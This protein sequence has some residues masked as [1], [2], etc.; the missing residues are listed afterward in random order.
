LERVWLKRYP[1]DVPAQIDPDAH[2]SLVSVLESSCERFADRPAFANLGATLR[3]AELD[4]ATRDFATYLRAAGLAPGDR[5]AVMLPNVLQY[6][7]AVF[8]ILRAGLTAVPVNPLY[9]ARELAHQLEDSG[10][11]AIIVLENFA[12]VVEAVLGRGERT[13]DLANA[14]LDE[15]IVTG[16]GD[17]LPFP[18]STIANLVVRYVRRAVPAWRIPGATRWRDAMRVAR[19][20]RFER[21]EVRGDA[22][23]FL[24]YTGGTTGTPKAAVLTHRNM[25]ANAEQVSAWLGPRIEPGAEVVITALPLYHIF[26]LTA[27][28]LCFVKFGGLNV[29]ITNP[30]DLG[31]FVRELGRWRFSAITGVNTLFDALLKQPDF[32]SLDFSRLRLSVAGGMAVHGRVAQRWAEVTGRPILEG[33][34]LTE[35]SPVVCANPYDA[36]R[37]SGTI[38]LPVP[39]TDV[40]VRDDEGRD[41]GAGE[42]GELCVRGPQVMAG[43]WQRPDE[44]ASVLS[45]DGWLRTGDIATI[46]GEGFVRIVD[47]KKDMILVSG[48][49]VYPSEVEEVVATHPGVAEV[50][51]VGVEDEECGEAVK[52]FVVAADGMLLDAADVVEH[53]R[54]HL[55]GYKVPRH[56][57]FRES[58]PKSNVGKILRRA[59]REEAPR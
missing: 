23:A 25:V 41:L 30:R 44:T 15:V 10:A 14:G 7:V 12:H 47:R 55:T 6:P 51:C 36:G 32:A 37:W 27:N 22:V 50:A 42:P 52:V 24:Q 11:R 53:C 49:N 2:P 48:F 20:L 57:E 13:G 45:E 28:C 43:Y 54:A 21:V 9:T 33:Y 18:R 56:V 34:G 26:C 58:L 4:L 19:R 5:V 39:S 59:L 8:G 16:V 38:G 29:L 31:G 17:L 1:R 35:T 40:A 3:F 46:D